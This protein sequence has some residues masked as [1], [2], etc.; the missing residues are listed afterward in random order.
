M[1][2][3]N[4]IKP[5]E[6]FQ[7]SFLKSRADITIG[8]GSAGAGKSYALL[9][10]PLMV[11]GDTESNVIKEK[12]SAVYF[13]RTSPE[14]TAPGGIW[15]E[16]ITLYSECDA[17][18][19]LRG[20]KWRFDEGGTVAFSHMQYENDKEKHK[21]AQYTHIFFDE[22]TTFTETQFFYMLSRNRSVSGARPRIYATTNPQRTGWV[23]RL[24]S[25][26][27]YPDDYGITA[28]QGKPIPER[29]GKVRFFIR[30]GDELVWADTAQELY[31]N[32][33][34]YF[35]AFDDGIPPRKKMKS[36]TFI[37]GTIYDN[38]ELLKKDPGYL[39]NLAAL[40][41]DER[42]MLMDGSWKHLDDADMLFEPV[43]V[44]ELF[45]NTWIQGTTRYISADLAFGGA[46]QFVVMV[47]E[48]FRIIACYTFDKTSHGQVLYHLK[49]IRR[50]YNI[51]IS[52]IVYDGDGGGGYLKSW[53]G[54]AQI[55]NNGSPA[56][57]QLPKS[58]MKHRQNLKLPYEHLKAQCYYLLAEVINNYKAF[59]DFRGQS[60][61]FLI[62]ELIATS[63]VIKLTS[64]GKEVLTIPNKEEMHKKVGRSPDHADAAMMR[65][66]F[67]LPIHRRGKEMVG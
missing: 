12:Y 31:D 66:I 46:D 42:S 1:T 2:P 17:D 24:I 44:E 63:K 14:I 5:Q 50:K 36:L 8:G 23:K 38:K 65:M 39:A 7:Y 4:E 41:E 48:G 10:V 59:A 28:L 30:L 55:F 3:I 53:L 32:N 40:P 27:I 54:N 11:L 6:G 58:D 21:S 56:I 64:S 62:E 15:D 26:W 43:P 9:M 47:W 18:Y 37:P 49:T 13:R 19:L 16:S 45:S 52:N 22:L 60:K 34:A 57:Q 29:A 67:E 33:K 20:R 35:N 25:W 61:E 51:P